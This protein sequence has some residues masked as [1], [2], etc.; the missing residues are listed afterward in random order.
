MNKHREKVTQYIRTNSRNKI[1][2]FRDTIAGIEPVNIGL[3]LS[4][5]IFNFKDKG[6]LPMKVS[7][8]LDIIL[9]GAITRHEDYGK[10]L[11]IANVG[12]LFENELKIDFGRILDNY[13][14]NQLLIVQWPGEIKN[15]NLYFLT[16]EKGTKINIS[17]LSHIIL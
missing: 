14:Q 16:K 13:S 8:E 3:V 10:I 15:G 11:S 7:M 2:F 6:K 1:V 5:S 9:Q 4:E 17:N 12:I